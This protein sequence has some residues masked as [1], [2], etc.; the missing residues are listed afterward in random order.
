MEQDRSLPNAT[1]GSAKDGLGPP[2]HLAKRRGA[3]RRSRRT[4]NS[5]AQTGRPT[6]GMGTGRGGRWREQAARASSRQW[7]RRV[8][9]ASF[10][11][12]GSQASYIVKQGQQLDLNLRP[13]CL[14]ASS[15]RHE[16]QVT[17]PADPMP[18][19]PIGFTQ[20]PF[21][22]IAGSRSAHSPPGDDHGSRFLGSAQRPEGEQLTGGAQSR[23]EHSPNVPAALESSLARKPAISGPRRADGLTH[24][25]G[26]VPWRGAGPEL[27]FRSWCA[28]AAGI[29][30]FASGSCCAVDTCASLWTLSCIRLGRTA[31]R[32]E[33]ELELERT[34]ARSPHHAYSRWRIIPLSGGVKREKPLAHAAFG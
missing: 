19:Q 11:D 6:A 2:C 32:S 7:L 18:I 25:D 5:W 15:L 29:H 34:L 16:R 22:A 20:Q 28:S 9:V 24:R 23:V 27:P 30:A 1:G 33:L 26:N 13:R 3:E 4:R 10:I 14:G 17:R 21:R 31:P 8:R 12:C